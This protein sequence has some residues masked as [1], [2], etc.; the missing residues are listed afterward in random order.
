MCLARNRHGNGNL[1]LRHVAEYCG[2]T[3]VKLPRNPLIILLP[4]LAL[5]EP[6]G[7]TGYSMAPL[8][9]NEP[10]ANLT[11]HAHHRII[12]RI[13]LALLANLHEQVQAF[14]EMG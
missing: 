6:Y 2:F 5:H 9:N 12:S 10:F 1:I 4:L 14:Q 11:A 8:P 3:A 7:I 13:Q